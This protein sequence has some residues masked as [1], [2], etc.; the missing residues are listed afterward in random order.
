MKRKKG[1]PVPVVLS[2]N[3]MGGDEG[4]LTCVVVTDLTERKQTEAVLAQ[5]EKQM[6]SLA[7]QLLEAQEKERKRIAHEIHDVLGSSLAAVKHSME[8]LVSNVSSC[9]VTTL[10]EGIKTLIPLVQD[11]IGEVRR[12]QSDLRPP[13]LDDLGILATLSWFCRRFQTIYSNI[14]VACQFGI[15]EEEIP[16]PLKI[17]IFRIS[18]EA[19]NNVAKHAQAGQVQLS[20]RK[21]ESGVELII[22]DKGKGFDLDSISQQEHWT[23]GVGL[24][25][26]KERTEFSG[27]R[28]QIT[29]STGK[30]TVVCAAWHLE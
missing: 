6:R 12:L 5:S 14:P 17:T 4:A 25:S 9:E 10:T 1:P 26:M 24:S 19:L 21:T 20:L 28:F 13:L 30:G 16:E 15:K 18:Q 11:T 27:G 29:S 2:F 3:A 23:K 22:E 7:N 8:N